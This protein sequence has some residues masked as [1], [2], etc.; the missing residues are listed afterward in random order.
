MK[1]KNLA[2]VPVALAAILWGMLVLFVKKFNQAGFTS[3]DI[4]CIRAYGSVAFLFPITAVIR[5]KLLKVRFKDLWCFVGTG[6]FSIVFFT[7]CYFRNLT[8]SSVAFSSILLY[9][10][11]VW[12]TL[13]SAVFF[14]EKI[15]A[16]KIAAMTMA[17][18]GCVFVSGIVQGGTSVTLLGLLLGLGSGIGYGLYS[19][20]SRFALDRGYHPLTISAYTFLLACIGVFPFVSIPSIVER[21]GTDVSLWL[22]ALGM[23]GLTGGLAYALY[24]LSLKYLEPGRAAVL[25]TIEPVVSTMMG[26][27]FFKESLSVLMIVGIVL[28]LAASVLIARAPEDKN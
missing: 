20:F 23:A 6:V 19:I 26:V 13:M 14:K 24:T 18:L 21:L 1:K 10:S 7:Y 25:A 2:A 3:M 8:V 16:M 11:P 28:V 5:P 15:T 27:L 17:L 4:I 22:L 9:T 12:V